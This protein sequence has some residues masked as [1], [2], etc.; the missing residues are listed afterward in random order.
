[1]LIGSDGGLL[2]SFLIRV[3]IFKYVIYCVNTAV[4]E[5]L[6]LLRKPICKKPFSITRVSLNVN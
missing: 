1:M 3:S 4:E 2:L 6:S 5:K